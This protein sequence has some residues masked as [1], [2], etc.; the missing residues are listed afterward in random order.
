MTPFGDVNVATSFDAAT[1]LPAAEFTF[2][3]GSA[4][5]ANYSYMP[6]SDNPE[7]FTSISGQALVDQTVSGTQVYDVT[8]PTGAIAGQFD[9]V[10]TH[11]I[12]ALGLSNE[13]ILV[14]TNTTGDTST[15]DPTVGF[16]GTLSGYGYENV[17][18]DVVGTDGAGNTV[19]DTLVT[20]FGDLNIPI[21]FDATTALTAA[22]FLFPTGS[23]AADLAS[24]LNPTDLLAD[25]SSLL[26][27]GNVSF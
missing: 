26:D 4:A 10:S 23:T 14:T 16:F 25:L 22:E 19:T 5:L 1:A 17:Y 27:L 2:P 11:E 3:T 7:D 24:S 12:D 9:G 8:D 6:D 18:S 21:S 15:D 20:P 13:E